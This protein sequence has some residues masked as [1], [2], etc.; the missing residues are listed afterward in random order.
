MRSA[1][2][3]SATAPLVIWLEES[4]RQRTLELVSKAYSVITS[5]ALALYLGLSVADA[6][7]VAESKGWEVVGDG[8]FKPVPVSLDKRQ[9]ATKQ[10][11]QSLTDY[12]NFL[13][14]E[15]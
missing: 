5:K 1:Q 13:E 14:S 6:T 3:K 7:K 8:L 9:V 12:V 15:Q 4:F 10:N 2:W 11:M